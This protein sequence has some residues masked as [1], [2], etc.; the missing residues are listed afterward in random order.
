L[1]QDT[2]IRNILWNVCKP[3]PIFKKV[4]K[5]APKIYFK[6]PSYERGT[7]I[8]SD[9]IWVHSRDLE[10]LY[11]FSLYD[12]E[13]MISKSC[14]FIL[15]TNKEKKDSVD[16]IYKS[17]GVIWDSQHPNFK[18]RKAIFLNFVRFYNLYF[19]GLS[20]IYK[21]LNLSPWYYIEKEI[22]DYIEHIEKTFY[23]KV[24]VFR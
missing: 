17:G 24:I 13:C 15:Y 22:E 8:D 4:S 2:F 20:P 7:H 23:K 11:C 21:T 12:N 6:Y 1:L 16:Y 5:I 10:I 18:V 19:F 14:R 3:D 9:A